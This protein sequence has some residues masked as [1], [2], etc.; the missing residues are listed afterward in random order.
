MKFSNIKLVASDLDGTLL[1]SSK[2]L[3]PQTL[4]AVE[5][6]GERNILFVPI[7]GRVLSSV[8]KF[9]KS[10][11]GLQ[12]IITSNGATTN[13]VPTNQEILS[14]HLPPLV[15][16]DIIPL[17]LRENIIVEAF[18]K[19]MAYCDR[20]ILEN[21]SSHGI[22][23]QHA[24]Y[25]ASTRTPVNNI[26]SFLKSNRNSIENIN[27]IFKD[28]EL[29]EE[30]RSILQDQNFASITSSSPINIEITN[31]EATKGISLTSLCKSLNITPDQVMC[32]GDSDNDIDMLK[33]FPFSFAMDNGTDAVKAFGKFQTESCDNHGVA[34][35]LEKFLF[36]T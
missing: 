30:M 36:L 11:P 5:K 25:M 22:I 35:A 2:E 27:L 17:V 13:H 21:L 7:T 14:C 23:G 32:F 12:Y 33:T 9:V 20:Y 26:F 8:P 3:S 10:L 28:M 15:V 16:E 19:G 18:S 24:F 34:K 1:N 31:K 4:E 6:L 29:R